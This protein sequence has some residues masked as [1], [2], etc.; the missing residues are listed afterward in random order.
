M[1]R[2]Q[3]N[4]FLGMPVRISLFHMMELSQCSHKSTIW[5]CRH[6]TPF[7]VLFFLVEIG[8]INKST[9]NLC[10]KLSNRPTSSSRI[11]SVNAR[12]SWIRL[13]CSWHCCKSSETQ[14]KVKLVIAVHRTDFKTIEWPPYMMCSEA[15]H[16]TMH[17][18]LRLLHFERPSP[19]LWFVW[20][21]NDKGPQ[22]TKNVLLRTFIQ[23]YGSGSAQH[24]GNTL[25]LRGPT[26]LRLGRETCRWWV[27]VLRD[28]YKLQ[29]I[30]KRSWRGSIFGIIGA[31]LHRQR[32]Q[33]QR[34]RCC[35]CKMRKFFLQA[36]QHEPIK[37]ASAA[38]PLQRRK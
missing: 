10:S 5:V 16:N 19:S 36:S 2:L 29:E 1:V 20:K 34:F 18:V 23:R 27:K 4:Y 38:W 25:K 26:T 9:N 30:G 17:T 37:A 8:F 21:S 32:R 11:I 24:N 15:S 14:R 13:S 3:V 35:F 12:K 28:H 22:D 31:K 6:L 33:Q 7:C